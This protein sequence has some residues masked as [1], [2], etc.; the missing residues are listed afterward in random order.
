MACE[1]SKD[2]D[3]TLALAD[4]SEISPDCLLFLILF[5]F[6]T[7]VLD[8]FRKKVNP[9]DGYR[10]LHVHSWAVSPKTQSG[11]WGV[12]LTSSKISLPVWWAQVAP[13]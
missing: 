10:P 1:C 3:Y 12:V 8:L 7:S 4:L 13:M 2:E 9:H 11:F 6:L 5:L